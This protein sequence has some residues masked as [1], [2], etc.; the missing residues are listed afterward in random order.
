M[1]LVIVRKVSTGGGLD[2]EKEDKQY[3]QKTGNRVERR[4]SRLWRMEG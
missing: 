2:G 3:T 4:M 1:K